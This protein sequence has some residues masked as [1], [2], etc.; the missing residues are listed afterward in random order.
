MTMKTGKLNDRITAGGQPDEQDLR[1]LKAEG[2]A[3]IINMRRDGEP[4]ADPAGDG[5]TAQ[6]LGMKYFH[7]PVNSADPKR[8]QVAAVKAALAQ[9]DGK[10]LVHCQGGGRACNM[11]LLAT[12]P[13]SG[14]G[15]KGM[16]AQAEAAGFPITNPAFQQLITEMLDRKG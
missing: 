1:N 13:A 15:S 5:K 6:A 3:G 8:E 2:F 12:A 16:F 11:A 9:I 7:I 4:G 10:V 14:Y